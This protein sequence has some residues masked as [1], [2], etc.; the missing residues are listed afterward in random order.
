MKP[1]T[2]PLCGHT[3]TPEEVGNLRAEMDGQEAPADDPMK[4]GSMVEAMNTELDDP[5]KQAAR[6]KL[7]E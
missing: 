5:K 7:K 2:C 4:A 3:M 6:A 1:M